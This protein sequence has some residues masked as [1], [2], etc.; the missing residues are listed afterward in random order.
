MTHSRSLVS[1][2]VLLKFFRSPQRYDLHFSK[3]S[4][5]SFFTLIEFFYVTFPQSPSPEKLASYLNDEIETDGNSF[6]SYSFLT[7][8]LTHIVMNDLNG[9]WEFPRWVLCCWSSITWLLLFSWQRQLHQ[10]INS[11]WTN[12]M[13]SSENLKFSFRDHGWS[14]MKFELY[15]NSVAMCTWKSRDSD[16]DA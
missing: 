13:P 7:P 11:S 16:T 8:T 15:V 5:L 4:W 1:T 10:H 14:L 3:Q 9:K 2:A 12:K 6:N